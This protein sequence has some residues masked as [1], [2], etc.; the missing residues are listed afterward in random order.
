MAGCGRSRGGIRPPAGWKSSQTQQ[1]ADAE[2]SQRQP[3]P[4]LDDQLAVPIEVGLA[5]DETFQA[6][7]AD[8]AQ[9]TVH[10]PV[11]EPAVEFAKGE[12]Q[13]QLLGEEGF[14]GVLVGA[15]LLSGKLSR[16]K[17]GADRLR[18]QPRRQEPVVDPTPVVAFTWPAASPMTKT[19]STYRSKMPVAVALMKTM[20]SLNL[21]AGTAPL[22]T[23]A[24][25]W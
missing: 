17:R 4:Q 1:R 16:G 22:R 15:E 14:P 23:S 20:L 11:A 13:R 21:A 9:Q 25:E 12:A 24:A 18:G 2:P 6:I 8:I 19:R 5:P 3:L 7:M 10:L